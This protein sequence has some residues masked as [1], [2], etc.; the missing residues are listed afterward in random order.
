MFL[1]HCRGQSPLCPHTYETLL[2]IVNM[3]QPEL[4]L[5]LSCSPYFFTIHKLFLSCHIWSPYSWSGRTI[6]GAV[7]GPGDHPWRHNWSGRTIRSAMDGPLSP[8]NI[9]L[10]PSTAPYLLR[11]DHP[12]RHEWSPLSCNVLSDYLRR[13]KF[14]PR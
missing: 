7:H 3:V 9:P 10:G 11:P 8:Y 4:M 12:R 1:K 2:G 14:I 13:R 5:Q 6:H